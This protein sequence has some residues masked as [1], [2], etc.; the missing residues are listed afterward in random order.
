MTNESIYRFADETRTTCYIV[1]AGLLIAVWSFLGPGKH[2]FGSSIGKLLSAAIL[3]FA[4]YNCM[5]STRR[6]TKSLPD[7][8]NAPELAPERG[9]AAANYGFAGLVFLLGVYIL[10]K[11]FWR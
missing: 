11:T 3:F 7:L 4:A 8:A 1:G 6:F 5:R 2:M 10:K 9:N